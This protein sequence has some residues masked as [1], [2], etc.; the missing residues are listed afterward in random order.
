MTSQA[1]S[2]SAPTHRIGVSRKTASLNP[3]QPA[4]ATPAA[5]ADGDRGRHCRP[6]QRRPTISVFGDSVSRSIRAIQPKIQ[7]WMLEM[8]IPLRPAHDG[9]AKLVQEDRAGSR[10]R[11]KTPS[12]ESI[13][14]GPITEQQYQK[15]SS[16]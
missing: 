15:K 3:V 13:D 4:A 10:Q 12:Q 6:R 8:P 2:A 1:T 7:S 5:P 9:V 11:S 14:H 16:C